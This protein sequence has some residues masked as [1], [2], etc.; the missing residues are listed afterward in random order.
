MTRAVLNAV[1]SRVSKLRA[2]RHSQEKWDEAKEI[3]LFLRLVASIMGNQSGLF[4]ITV[5]VCLRAYRSLL[6][7]YKKMLEGPKST[8]LFLVNAIYDKLQNYKPYTCTSLASLAQSLDPRL[9]SGPMEDRDIFDSMGW[10]H[11]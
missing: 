3:E 4:Y 9:P 2:F 5:N 10:F 11:L 1:D 6:L 8:L 7:T